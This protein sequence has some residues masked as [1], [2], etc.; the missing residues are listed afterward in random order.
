MSNY[1][2]SNVYSIYKKKI[3]NNIKKQEN[4]ENAKIKEN[5]NN[6]FKI[7]IEK[8]NT[9]YVNNQDKINNKYKIWMKKIYNINKQEIIIKKY[10][11]EM[12]ILYQKYKNKI[13]SI[14]NLYKKIYIIYDTIINVYYLNQDHY[15]EEICNDL[16]KVKEIIINDFLQQKFRDDV[17]NIIC[18]HSTRY[19][20]ND[21]NNALHNFLHMIY[22]SQN[23]AMMEKN[24]NNLIS[25]II[26]YRHLFLLIQFIF[27][28]TF[29]KYR[30]VLYGSNSIAVLK[31]YLKNLCL[32]YLNSKNKNKAMYNLIYHIGI[33]I[34]DINFKSEVNK[35]F[36]QTRFYKRQAGRVVG[37]FEHLVGFA[38]NIVM[39]ISYA[40]NTITG[41]H[42]SL[43]LSELKL[44]NNIIQRYIKILNNYQDLNY[45]DIAELYEISKLYSSLH[46]IK[47]N[48]TQ[49]YSHAYK[50]YREHY[51]SNY[52]TFLLPK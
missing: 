52:M 17:C 13:E 34:D 27:A 4:N 25:K 19:T 30:H 46:S 33:E 39:D 35:A 36:K 48:F 38:G 3:L 42:L 14:N 32:R 51:G 1:Y 37:I 45:L 44:M 16:V 24:S 41:E 18:K 47:N 28:G 6:S 26:V 7:E 2:N 49:E 23:F 15:F 40:A 10:N 9:L 20:N 22:L 43:P 8:I 5:I 12:N 21:I 29:G 50:S 31:E 11:N